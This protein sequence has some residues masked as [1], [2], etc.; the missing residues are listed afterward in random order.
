M[1][2]SSTWILSTQGALIPTLICSRHGSVPPLP[3]RYFDKNDYVYFDKEGMV[4]EKGT[5]PVEGVPC[6]EGIDPL[7]MK[8][9]NHCKG[10]DHDPEYNYKESIE[11]V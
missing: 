7:Y 8:Q 6:V 4:V 1:V 10:N 9:Q 11:A 2:F 3:S 5:I